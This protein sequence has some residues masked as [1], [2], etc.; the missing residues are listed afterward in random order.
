M[1]KNLLNRYIWLIDTIYHADQITF[2]DVN[3]RWLEC[4][5][6]DREPLPLRTFH[7]HKNSIEDLFGIRIGCNKRKG[8]MY[9]IENREVFG[10]GDVRSWL[11]NTFN[12]NNLI[13]ENPSLNDKVFFD[14]LPSGYAHIPLVLEAIRDEQRIEIS[15]QSSWRTYTDTFEVEPYCVKV[16]RQRWYMIARDPYINKIRIYA[17]DE[18]L[19]IRPLKRKYKIH[20]QFDAN[21]FLK[22]SFG[23]V[24][25]EQ[26]NPEIIKIKADDILRKHLRIKHLHSSQ[27]EI[28][29]K[30]RYSVFK[31]LICPT[32]DFTQAILSHGEHL[33]V[34]WPPSYREEFARKIKELCR[35][36]Q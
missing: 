8:Y 26:I 29:T 5:W 2:E 1:S 25:D 7:N 36:Y 34:V 23:M 27:E 22:N 20:K 28:E 12:V 30:D 16:F 32:T 35:L 24:V 19:S 4:E 9:F 6:G 11:F 33:E 13:V 18:I 17:L 31:Y 14:S 10:K 15:Y 3:Q 21:V